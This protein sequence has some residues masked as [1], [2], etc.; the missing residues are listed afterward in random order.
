MLEDLSNL[1]GNSAKFTTKATVIPPGEIRHITAD[2]SKIKDK[3]G[4]SPKGDFNKILPD[5]IEWWKN[6]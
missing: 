3:L 4:Y 1:S 6:Q 2:I 5:I